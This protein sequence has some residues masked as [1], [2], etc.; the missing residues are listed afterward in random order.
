MSIR[1]W[2]FFADRLAYSSIGQRHILARRQTWPSTGFSWVSGG[3]GVTV[4]TVTV[5]R[6]IENG[7]GGGLARQ[8]CRRRASTPPVI[9][10]QR[11]S[12]SRVLRRLSF[13]FFFFFFSLSDKRR[14]V[15]LPFSPR[16]NATVR[17][18][19]RVRDNGARGGKKKKERKGKNVDYFCRTL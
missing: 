15:P 4:V 12:G 17:G 6:C 19:E 18:G 7:K 10:T 5:D 16:M 2:L 8:A 9:S 3:G 13:F 1:R 14:S 11:G